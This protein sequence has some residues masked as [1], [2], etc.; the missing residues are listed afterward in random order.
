MLVTKLEVHDNRLKKIVFYLTLY[1][2]NSSEKCIGVRKIILE[3]HQDAIQD[4]MN[5]C[6]MT[7]DIFSEICEGHKNNKC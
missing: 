7:A 1:V 4:I 5:R 6:G 3:N 2:D